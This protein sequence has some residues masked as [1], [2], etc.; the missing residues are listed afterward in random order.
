MRIQE[1]VEIMESRRD[2]SIQ[3]HKGSTEFGADFYFEEKNYV[4][5]F[6]E[7]NTS[8]IASYN[9]IAEFSPIKYN[10]V[11]TENDIKEVIQLENNTNSHGN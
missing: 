10:Y 2:R 6:D 4:V 11:M 8:P 5:V 1:L 3:A 7:G 9:F